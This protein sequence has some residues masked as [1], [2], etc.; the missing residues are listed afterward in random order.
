[1][2]DIAEIFAGP[3]PRYY[4][5]AAERAFLRDLAAAIHAICK[6]D[7]ARLAD[8]HILTP[9]RRAIRA[10]ADA[11]MDA[12][13]AGQ[14]LLLPKMKA[15]GDIDEDEFVVF[16]GNAADEIDLPPAI[17]MMQRRATLARL[18]AARD[19][20]F[21]DGQE[22]WAGAIA[23]ADELGK[24]L[25]SFYT[26]EIDSKALGA[27]A[28]ENFAAHWALS[29]EFL[30]IVIKAW[31]EYLEANAY[32]DPAA[33]RAALID[34]Q[35]Q[36]WREAPP[37]T[38][39]IIAGTTGSAPSVARLM[40]VVAGLPKGCVVLPGLDLN[41]S[42]RV[43]ETIDEPHPQSGLK[44]LLWRLE[45]DRSAVS[46]FPQ[47]SPPNAFL[48][49][50]AE[51]I[52]LALRPANVSDDWHKWAQSA[53]DQKERIGDALTDVRLVEAADEEREAGAIALKL[54]ETI[55][56]PD[57]TA[58]LVTPD[59]NLARRVAAKLRRWDV[60]VDDSAGVPFANTPCGG[61]LRL[62]AAWL[63][64]ISDP[65]A[66][67]ALI[68]HPMTGAGLSLDARAKAGKA[69][70]H[71]LRGLTPQPGLVGL[72]EKV[73]AAGDTAKDA[74]P[75]L[76]IVAEAAARQPSN[77]AAFADRLK[78]H[79]AIAEVFAAS[80]AENGEERLWRGDDGAAGAVLVAD[81]LDIAD[82]IDAPQL[83][84][85]PDI[86]DQLIAG[87]V[88]RRASDVH[89]RIAIL[90][91]L[92]ARLQSADVVVLGGLNEGVWPRD[93]AID[94]FL[95][96]PMRQMIGLPSP[97]RRIGL[98]AHDFTQLAAR[99]EVMLTRAM[100]VSGAPS[101]PSRWIVRLKNILKSLDL[102]ETIDAARQYAGLYER[103]DTPSSVTPHPAP[104]P[105]PP[106]EARPRQLSVTR[107]EKLMRDPFAIYASKILHLQK[108]DPPGKQ[109]GPAEF[110][111]LFHKVFEKYAKQQ[112][113]K[114]EA[115]LARLKTLFSERAKDYG[116]R[117]E[118]EAFWWTRIDEALKW[119]AEWD[120]TRRKEGAPILLEESGAL[121]IDTPGGA[122]TLTALAD[123]I[124]R[125]NDGAF[126]IVD[127]KTGAP[128]TL[129]QTKTFSP[130]LPL[131]GLIL[132]EGGFE[133]VDQTSIAVMEYV[134]VLN[135]GA[136]AKN[137]IAVA[138]KDA[139][140]LVDEVEQGLRA[141]IAHFDDPDTT[142]PS[143]PRAEYLDQYGDFDHLA[144]RREREATGA[145]E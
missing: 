81:I 65:V 67:L 145:D 16:D 31:P 41:A 101:K 144:R 121:T 47:S 24:L 123:R 124:D 32:M 95:S 38:P 29:L 69:L 52:S 141:L 12:A 21:F 51:L 86:F 62:V 75:L 119:F 49:Q 133:D 13:P 3:A 127:Y 22:R 137:T 71:A 10:L 68:D 80:D 87:V 138:G 91:P 73:A 126:A 83:A 129:K 63:R 64:N 5:I 85:Y 125:Q 78:A 57:K 122:F 142:Y 53:K 56:T 76:D 18:V 84:D 61:F 89:P 93:A 37:Q 50:R 42:D 88:V 72:K 17:P 70:D 102:H 92:E 45:I 115:P 8:I 36:R 55:N 96:R 25:D 15:I 104:N 109:L 34:A 74:A 43:W 113:D 9:T 40:Q 48:A 2:T 77:D 94:P 103:L 114:A 6:D 14:A 111:Q 108:L 30:D 105:T 143:Q 140:A 26:E 106:V 60:V 59:R 131:T 118:H 27:V 46:P 44:D 97:E 134:R 116:W 79:I 54:R 110:G 130:Q 99:G 39:V 90:G 19:R 112:T 136:S 139:E 23:A 98:S 20:K 117:A 132:R 66:L 33:R 28:P 82:H 4:S 120:A 107:I 7:P 100:R 1:M 35:T 135:R 11:L 128:P 58:M